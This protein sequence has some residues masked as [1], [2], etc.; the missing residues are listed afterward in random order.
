MQKLAAVEATQSM[1]V[2][3]ALIGE[4]LFLSIAWPSA[5][6]WCGIVLVMLGMTVHSYISGQKKKS[7]MQL[8]A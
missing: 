1:E 5:L 3:F 7:V 4:I 2:V 8:N 6:S